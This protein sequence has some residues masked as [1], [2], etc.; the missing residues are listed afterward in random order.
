M[1]ALFAA[2]LSSAA[3]EMPEPPEV[4]FPRLP[5]TA[6]S[7]AA[8]VPAGWKI[9][10]RQA[11]D[12]NGDGKSD[13]ALLLKMDSKANVLP[14]PDS[15]PPATLDTNPF[16]LAIAFAEGGG[17]YRVTG[18]SR[19]IFRRVEFPHS[20]D[21][22]PGEGDS[23]RIERGT[24][25]LSNEYL[26]GHESYRFRWE[27]DAFRLIGYETGG[28]SGGCA[29]TISINYLTGKARWENT[30]IRKDKGAAVARRVKPG[31]LLTL[32]SFDDGNFI[33]SDTI[34]GEPPPCDAQ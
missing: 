32:E 2:L 19:G 6:A 1:R 25:L 13:L 26:R 24:L 10:E 23:V 31:P 7:E 3:A 20:G 9:V 12:L 21:L 8:I 30:P 4:T 18:S 15:S 17:G 11:G 34:A 16:L 5:Q 29:E 22:P 28:S 27:K 33:P 14:I